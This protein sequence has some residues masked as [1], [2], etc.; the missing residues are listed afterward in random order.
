MSEAHQVKQVPYLPKSQ[1]PSL[2]TLVPVNLQ[3]ATTNALNQL[4]QRIG[5]LDEYV[6]DRLGYG[7]P[8]ELHKYFSAEQA[9]A[10]ALVISNLE[11]GAGFV[12]G[13]QTG[14][15]KGRVVAA[16]IHY[17]KLTG[18]VPIFVTKEPSLYADM[19]RDLTNIN[20]P[21]FR[22]F[23]TD[24][25]LKLPLPDGR[26]LKTSPPFHQ[27]EMA[28]LQ[29]T[30]NLGDYEAI[31]TT[32]SQLQTVRGQE[33]ARHEFLRTFARKALLIL[34]ESH[35]AGG[36]VSLDREG[37]A[38]N[39]SARALFVR[40]LA[41]LADGVFYSSAT[42]AKRPDIM[43]LY[44]KTDMRLAVKNLSNL[45]WMVQKGGIPLQQA[46]ATMLTES[47]QYL[48]RERSFEGVKFDPAIVPVN[49]QVAENLAAI[50][51]GV[52]DFDRFKRSALKKIDKEL[53]AEAKALLGDG[54]IGE[55]G[56]S[57]TNFTSIMHN[58]IDQMLLALKA[59]ATVQKSVEL[60]RID[61]KP[62]IALASTMGS[63]IGQYAQ[64][65]HLKPG[66]AINLSFG[67][68]LRR[69]L[70]R[71]REIQVGNPYGQKTRQRLN[72]AELGPE[73]VAQYEAV[74][75]L[76]DETDLSGIPIS[77]I[78]YIK[79]RLKQ[80][81]YR[82]D[83]ITGREHTID[84]SADGQT[85]YQR[86]SSTQKD[87][88]TSVTNVKAFNSGQLDV[89]ILN[90][91]GSTGIS[92]HA[93]QEFSDRRRRHMI[94]AQPERDI[95]QFMQMLGRIHRTG[96]VVTPNYT[97]LMA[98]IPAEKRPGAVLAK[99][100]A[101]LNA[102]TTA[103]RQNGI[104]LE[105]VPD[106][107][108]EYGDRVAAEI[109]S[110]FPELHEQLDSPLSGGEELNV[111]DAIKKVTGRIPLLPLATQEKLYD[112]IE[113]EYL[114]WVQRQE[115]MGESIL[116]A[117]YLDLDAR[118]LARLEVSPA[119]SCS[120]SPFTS[121]VNLEVID[122]KTPQKPLTTLQVI[123]HVRAHL[124]LPE[125]SSINEHDFE[126]TFEIAQTSANERITRLNEQIDQYRQQQIAY[127]KTPEKIEKLDERLE[128]QRNRLQ[129]IL[130]EFPAGQSVRLVTPNSNVFYGVV[131]K[132]WQ[133]GQQDNPTVPSGWRM[134]VLL[135]DPAREI[136]IPFS[137]INTGKESAI[138]LSSQER[139][140]DDNDIY[141]SFDLKQVQERE[142]RQILTGNLLRVFEQ[143]PE[144]KL[145][146]FTDQRGQMRQGL[147]MPKDFEIEQSLQKQPVLMP[148]VEDACQFLSEKGRQLKTADELLT[149]KP[150]RQGDGFLL[151]TAKAKEVAG[152]YYLDS[153]LLAATGKEFYSVGDRMECQ[154]ERDRL[155]AVLEAIMVK[156]SWR[157]AAFER[158]NEARKMLG[159]TLPQLEPVVPEPLAKEADSST[160]RIEPPVAESPVPESLSRVD[161]AQFSQALVA[162][163][164]SPNPP[165]KASSSAI[166]PSSQ[167]KGAAAKNVAKFLSKAGLAEMVASN[168]DYHL[169][170][171]NEP[172]IPLVV[173]RQ[174]ERLYLTHYLSQNGDT[175]VD[176]EMVFNLKPS[177]HLQ[178]IE[179]AVN[180][181]GG[182]YRNCDLSYA[183]MF[184]ANILDQGFAEAAQQVL[185]GQLLT[186]SSP[187][188]TVITELSSNA[189]PISLQPTE[190]QIFTTEQALQ[191]SL[192]SLEAYTTSPPK[193]LGVINS[194]AWDIGDGEDL[195]EMV[196]KATELP[197]PSSASNTLLKQAQE[198]VDKLIVSGDV[199]KEPQIFNTESPTVDSSPQFQ[200]ISSSSPEITLAEREAVNSSDIASNAQISEL[201]FSEEK[202]SK[203]APNC[204]LPTEVVPEAKAST[205]PSLSDL[206]DWYQV[207]QSLGKSQAYL[208]RIVEVGGELVMGQSFS[209]KAKAAREKDLSDHEAILNSLREWYVAAR[210]LGKS[211]RYL[212]RIMTV[213]QEFKSGNSLSDKAL[214]V[215][216]VDL[217]QSKQ[218]ATQLG[219]S[220]LSRDTALEA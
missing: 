31:F 10:C 51:S 99:K 38:K 67:D 186:E 82:L 104:T 106:F 116:E 25:P 93:C 39:T 160:L 216:K 48:R 19:L 201:S 13:D 57:S 45:T 59:E 182:E 163:S 151:Q 117:Q 137:K 43:D 47:G 161:T 146:N 87:K 7:T 24:S 102:N 52:L 36:S 135:A 5:S 111:D 14:I 101:S 22:P 218:E 79:F 172:Y 42:Y 37:R 64:L 113:G 120:Y 198:Q 115:A 35:E 100:M 30:G 20:Q 109:M 32:Y 89:L 168:E 91:S 27:Q 152:R 69:Y 11:K 123:N 44:A 194:S 119:D 143:F 210:G 94:I 173:E 153:T 92:L 188:I 73:G 76:I 199:S 4:E 131:A 190:H 171:P 195:E 2:D 138:Q 74:L 78:D 110:N 63:F 206:R 177:G 28:D 90:R 16:T 58:L 132:I 54:A 81:G 125:I 18:R 204:Q 213:A 105:N 179:T 219:S 215:M 8:Q 126:A 162:D 127:L 23:V 83:E 33:T 148:T 193:S 169:S 130:E 6:A 134:Q 55:A 9:D 205:T 214:A 178:L 203:I 185:S 209:D 191:P 71:S 15:G 70:E 144:G 217:A 212:G 164:L 158:Q 3:T 112:L 118:T 97:L 85:F 77:P 65:N 1:G 53:K 88:A 107:M 200:E 128:K 26:T 183:K 61:E 157:L 46:L 40:E 220:G 133:T 66:D 114:E 140:W 175:F 49:H 154:V 189:S 180:S 150:Q 196:T 34:D 176:S 181:I 187:K 86:R 122:A 159:L 207:A 62:L 141:E 84:Y 56:A 136:V 211:Q 129:D 80:E 184:S 145:I 142:Q 124:K 72:D 167:Q 174:S 149:L 170:I 41:E 192:F 17:A 68:L 103:A 12:I 98:D 156:K 96:Q 121:A 50:M 60:L 21:H 155:H 29:R 166:L 147:I 202:P 95:N 108:N 197:S 139:D 75:D 165:E 208:E